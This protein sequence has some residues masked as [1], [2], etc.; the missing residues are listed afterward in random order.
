MQAQWKIGAALMSGDGVAREPEQ[1]MRWLQAA[2]AEGSLGRASAERAHR[3]RA[4]AEA[5]A[6]GRELKRRW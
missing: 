3:G 1:G 5:G 2:A 4:P 6:G